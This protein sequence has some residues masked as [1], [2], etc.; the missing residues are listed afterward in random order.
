MTV[1]KVLF[2]ATANV[3]EAERSQLIL[4]L[5]YIPTTEHSKEADDVYED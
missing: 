3:G 2:E 1:E 5:V 4:A